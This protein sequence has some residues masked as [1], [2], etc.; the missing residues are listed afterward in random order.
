M[1]KSRDNFIRFIVENIKNEAENKKQ[2][3]DLSKGMVECILSL[4][5]RDK[6]LSPA[7]KPLM[8]EF[9][10]GMNETKINA[11]IVTIADKT[12]LLIID[13]VVQGV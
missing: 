2:V 5:Q 13:E 4:I 8:S 1:S 9:K 7:L 3:S 10:Q 12:V 11:E 6:F